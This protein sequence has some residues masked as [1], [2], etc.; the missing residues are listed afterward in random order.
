M[1]VTLTILQHSSLMLV[2]DATNSGKNDQIVP[3][4]LLYVQWASSIHVHVDERFKCQG[5]QRTRGPGCHI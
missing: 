2:K 1:L 3:K 5:R 4:L